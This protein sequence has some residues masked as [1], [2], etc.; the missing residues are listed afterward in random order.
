MREVARQIDSGLFERAVLHS[1]KVSTAFR[2][3]QPQ[4]AAHFKD[5][6]LLDFLALPDTHS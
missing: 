5:A 3:I 2:E 1:P 4:A 6:Y